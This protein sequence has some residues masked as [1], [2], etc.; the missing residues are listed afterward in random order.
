MKKIISKILSK[1]EKIN[2]STADFSDFELETINSA[3]PFTMTS[4]ERMVS[5]I[6]AT[7]YTIKNNIEGDFVE[8]GVWKG[9]SAML[10]LKTLL[11]YGID[12]KKIYLYDTF[13]GM[14]VPT[15]KDVSFTGKKA[16]VLLQEQ[17]KA[18][19]HSVWCY[20]SLEE[21]KANI[22][23]VGYPE[24]NIVFVQGKVEETIPATIPEKICLLRLDTDWYE[25]TQHELLHLYPLLAQRGIL[26]IDDYGHWE[27]CRKA[28]DEYFEAN[29]IPIFLSR[30]DYTGR[31]AV[32]I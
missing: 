25:S 12:N 8:C 5:L 21:V 31:L 10:I 9:G 7:E 13:E 2:Y 24:E 20:S 28:V 15:E 23:Q 30:I 29:E 3:K 16:E 11:K 26:I 17:D 4:P 19:S 14:S 32:K 27:G 22:R 18:V 1:K 6:R